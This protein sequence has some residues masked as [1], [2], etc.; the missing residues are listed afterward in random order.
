MTHDAFR[1]GRFPVTNAEYALFIAA[2]GYDDEQWWDTDAAKAWR[3]GEGQVEGMRQGWREDRATLQQSWTEEQIRALVAQGRIT[4]QQADDWIAIRNWS[5]GEFETWL[6]KSFPSGEIYRQPRFWN[7]PDFDNP[8]QP[9]VGVCWHEARAYCAW[10]SAQT[11]MAS[12]YRMRR[13]GRHPRAARRRASTLTA[14]N[15]MQRAATRSRATSGAPHRWVSFLA[16]KRPMASPT[17]AETC[18]SGPAAPISITRI[19]PR[20]SAKA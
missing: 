14:I 2:G 16:V 8:A 11:G 19:S 20:R 7:D 3:R 15:S 18:G 13:S 9:V 17:C 4:S 10:L 1:I 5:D 12:L 6:E